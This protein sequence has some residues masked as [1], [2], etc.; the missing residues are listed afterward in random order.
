[1][2]KKKVSPLKGRKMSPETIE[3]IK[4]ARAAKRAEREAGI[5]NLSERV[6]DALVMFRKAYAA[7]PEKT[8]KRDNLPDSAAMYL[9][10][11][12]RVLEGKA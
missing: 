4:A 5:V 12:I 6:D 1:M 2:T 8:G 10:L 7:L 11:G 3:K 9:A